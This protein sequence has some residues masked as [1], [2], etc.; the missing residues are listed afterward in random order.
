MEYP[1]FLTEDK[2]RAEKYA[3]LTEGLSTGQRLIVERL[4]A[5]I[6]REFAREQTTTGQI[7]PFA[8][9]AKPI[10][11]RIMPRT[12][13]NELVSIQPM[14]LPTAKI[15]Y[16]TIQYADA[17]APTVA[18]HVIDNNE[19]VDQ[20]NRF[21]AS[22]SVRGEALGTGDAANVAFQTLEYPIVADSLTVYVNSVA[23]AHTVNAT[24]GAITMTVAPAA[25]ATV[26]ADYQLVM[27]GLGGTGNARRKG[28]KLVMASD[29]INAETSTLVSSHTLE[30]A[31]DYAA[32]HD[33][34]LDEELSDAMSEELL[35][36]I[37]RVLIMGIEAGATAGN[38]SWSKTIPT[39]QLAK[40]HYETLMHAVTDTAALIYRKRLVWPNWLLMNAATFSFIE[41][42][43][44]FRPL[45]HFAEN[46][47]TIIGSGPNVFGTIGG[48]YK[49]IVDP[50]FTA[51]TILVGYKGSS[52]QEAGYVFAPY[53][54]AKT[55][56]FMDP[57]DMTP[58][59][60]MMNRYGTKLINGNYFG[61]VTLTA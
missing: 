32:Y 54:M 47:S 48:R 52:W 23:A 51:D 44:S 11:R 41:K 14:P 18:G 30:A 59:Q 35:L 58:R 17:Q 28:L 55:G 49:V 22:G 12:I 16:K 39:G 40:E 7:V 53:L 31:Q 29:D 60:G 61:T 50:L 6:D 37:D 13:A 46:G 34:N 45:G 5:N 21:Y 42:M 15:F 20:R 4:M 24:T 25:A 56:I 43:Q 57:A 9:F 38:T 10:I 26:T 19:G 3:A 36:E 1:S 2:A 8:K 33:G 27:E